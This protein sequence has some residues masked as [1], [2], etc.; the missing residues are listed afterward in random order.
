MNIHQSNVKHTLQKDLLLR[1]MKF[2]RIRRRLEMSQ[3][4]ERVR[5]L[6]WL[7]KL[8]EETG[9]ETWTYHDNL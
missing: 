7:P 4:Q 6:R 9:D 1:K 8:L 2:K 5:F 3:K